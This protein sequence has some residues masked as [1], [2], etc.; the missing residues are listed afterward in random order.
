MLTDTPADVAHGV[1]VGQ[2][3]QDGGE[4][5][6]DGTVGGV[7]EGGRDHQQV[8]EDGRLYDVDVHLLVGLHKQVDNEHCQSRQTHEELQRQWKRLEVITS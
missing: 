3:Y 5:L 2:Q 7:Q 6:W 4:P 8:E 1:A